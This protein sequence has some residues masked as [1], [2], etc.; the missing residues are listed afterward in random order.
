MRSPQ[1]E[2]KYTR[3]EGEKKEETIIRLMRKE[4]KIKDK[5]REVEDKDFKAYFKERRWEVSWRWKG[6]EVILK[7]ST[8]CYEGTMKGEMKAKFEEEVEKWISEGIIGGN[9]REQ[10][11]RTGRGVIP[12]MA[13]HQSSKGKLRPVLDF[14]KLNVHNECYT[15]DEIVSCEETLRMWS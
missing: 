9:G 4:I 7:S 15:G 8:G 3:R 6:E 14:R 1:I 2:K 10:D 12:P 11:D 13:V 5:K